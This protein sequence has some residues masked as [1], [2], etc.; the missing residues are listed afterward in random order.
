MISGVLS[1]FSQKDGVAYTTADS[2]VVDNNV[3]M[4]EKDEFVN[5]QNFVIY[6]TDENSRD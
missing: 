1:L 5:A 2:L 6:K 4:L 3:F